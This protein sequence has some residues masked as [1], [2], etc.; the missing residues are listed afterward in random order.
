MKIAKLKLFFFIFFS[1][2]YSQN[3]SNMY[4]SGE[5]NSWGATTMTMNDLGID[6]WQVTVQSDGDDGSS[7]FKLRNSNSNYDQNWSRGDA[8]TIGSKTT[9]YNP[10]GGN[11]RF[12]ESNGKFYTFIIKDVANSNNSEGY[13]FEFSQ[14]PVSIS[15]VTSSGN[16]LPSTAKSITIGLSGTPDNNERVYV[17]YTTD[18]WSSSAIVEG[19]PSSNSININIPGQSAGVTVKYYVF[20]SIAGISNGDADLAT[21]KFDNNSGNN[22]SYYVESGVGT[23]SG[24]S[25]FRMLSSPV[26]GQILGSL[27][28]NLWTQG[29]TGADVTTATANVWTLN[30]SG[31]SWTALSDIS[32]SGT[33]IAAGQ[34]FLVYVF[35]D[36]DNDGTG[37]LPVNISVSGTENSSDATYGSIGNGDWGLAGNPYSS[38][39]DWD[40]ISKTNITSTVYVWDDAANAYKSWNGSS[41]GLTDGLIAPYQGFW[42]EASGGTGSITI[43]TSDKATAAGTLYR[44]LDIQETG[45]VTFN[46]NCSDFSDQTFLSFQSTGE[47][48]LD[49]AD[50]YKLFPL[51]HSDRLVALSY[52]DDTGLDINNLPYDYEESIII[53][54]DIMKLQ[55]DE[56]NYIT[57]EEEITFSWDIS[58][59]PDHISLKLI[60]QITNIETDMNLLSSISFNAEPKGSF[61]TNFIGPVGTYPVVGVPRFSLLVSYD[62]LSSGENIKLLPS[63]LVLSSAHPNPFNPSTTISFDLP[64]AGKVS[65]NIYDLKGALVGTLLNEN[66]V[67]GTYKYRWT[68]NS[69]IAS[70]MYLFELKTN[71]KTRHQ[72]ITY[73]K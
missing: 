33:S 15:S 25:G 3:Q 32:G 34:G 62:A 38:T 48:G 63:E 27:L 70:G 29:M 64:E 20:T 71:N 55:L 12:S 19:D 18:N 52:A 43:S 59:L 10:N 68:P 73:I 7:E 13:I 47:V 36:T 30:V 56:S 16:A 44:V 14:A 50:G 2:A 49:N 42:V 67:A 21:I 65:L 1:F 61:G 4:F 9:F 28:T 60:D 45:S 72:K 5:M 31:Q 22:Y 39:I 58:N 69:E 46:V 41:G 51:S 26:S 11:S 8:I 17:R 66:K 54:F 23:I 40:L 6:T 24:N 57:Q 35:E 37:D 53:P